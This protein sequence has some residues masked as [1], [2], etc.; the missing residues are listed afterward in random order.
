MPQQFLDTAQIVAGFQQMRGEGMPKQMRVNIGVD[1]LLAGP[2]S[3]PGLHRTRTDARAT[4]ADE[5]R[6]LIDLCKLN[7]GTVPLPQRGQGLA[8]H[9]DNAVLVALARN[10]NGSVEE[11]DV[12]AI[13]IGQLGQT[14]AGRVQQLENGTITIDQRTVALNV[15]QPGHAIGIEIVGQTLLAFRG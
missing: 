14:Q 15:Q 4:I 1:A 12:A 7:S 5:Q 9:R 11:V 6:L 3:N 2:V 10:M 8:A 13:E